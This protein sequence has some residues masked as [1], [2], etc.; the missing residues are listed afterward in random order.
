MQKVSMTA[1]AIIALVASLL[2]IPIISRGLSPEKLSIATVSILAHGLFGIADFFRPILVRNISDNEEFATYGNLFLPNLV[3]G[4][5]LSAGSAVISLFVHESYLYLGLSISFSLLLFSL[6]TP[7]WGTMDGNFQMGTAYLVRSLS[8]AM[9]YGLIAIGAVFDLDYMNYGAISISNLATLIIF[10][11]FARKYIRKGKFNAGIGYIRQASYLFV[12]NVFKLI[13][14]FGDRVFASAYLP[15]AYVGGYNLLS[16]LSARVN[17]PAQLASS[18]YYPVI[19]RE[20][21]KAS[22]LLWSGVVFSTF[23]FAICVTIYAFGVEIF[24]WYLGEGRRHI[25]PI[26]CGL[27]ACFSNYSLSFFGQSVARSLSLDRSLSLSFGA[28]AVLGLSYSLINMHD[29]NIYRVMIIALLMK[30]SSVFML[31]GLL[32]RF[33]AQ[34]ICGLIVSLFSFSFVINIYIR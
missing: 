29:M 7:L 32:R 4:L 23:L 1:G 15:G 20:P 9:L 31:L 24:V 5:S 19:C 33:P 21:Q 3:I 34:S 8:V 30:S 27:L 2:A 26:F 28:S 12:Q 16:D 18:Y 11:L 25:F 6:Y 10:W 13:N 14:D 17:F 22:L